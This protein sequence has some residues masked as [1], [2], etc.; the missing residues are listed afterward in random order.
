MWGQGHWRSAS[1]YWSIYRRFKGVLGTSSVYSV[2]FSERE[3]RKGKG[4]RR[5]PLMLI[6]PCHGGYDSSCLT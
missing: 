5:G 4:E 3:R 6:F 1:H 2:P